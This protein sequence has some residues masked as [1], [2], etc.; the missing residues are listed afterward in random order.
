MNAIN[1]SQSTQTI[2]FASL[3]VV[4]SIVVVAIASLFLRGGGV[5]NNSFERVYVMNADGSNVRPLLEE[6]S[7]RQATPAWSPDGQSV[8]M[9]MGGGKDRTE[10][11][12]LW[13]FDLGTKSLRPLTNGSTYD[14]LP[15]WSPDGSTIVFVAHD[16]PLGSTP[17]TLY[18][19][20]I[21]GTGLTQLTD[22]RSAASQASWSPDS[23]QLV[24]TLGRGPAPQLFTLNADG[25]D[26][27]PIGVDEGVEPSWSHDGRTITFTTARDIAD[28]FS[29]DTQTHA[30]RQLTHEL[31][32]DAFVSWSP[33]DSQF[34]F[35]SDRTGRQE[36]YVMRPDGSNVVNLS[37]PSGLSI[38]RASWSPDGK[39]IVFFS[40]DSRH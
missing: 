22:G 3:A 35:I 23:K 37:K 28:L 40:Q 18:R 11:A 5:G 4:A 19:I 6:A 38:L 21:D 31:G 13:I 27:R 34:L 32:F 15:A 30:V 39:Q 7:D 26:L 29:F 10:P 9:S 12:H 14:D 36:L 20:S 16:L 2:Q 24:V 8:V 1:R 33:D 17:P 25:T